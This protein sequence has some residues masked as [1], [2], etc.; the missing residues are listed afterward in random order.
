MPASSRKMTASTRDRVDGKNSNRNDANMITRDHDED[1][2]K[3]DGTGLSKTVASPNTAACSKRNDVNSSS[4]FPRF[5]DNATKV[6]NEER[7]E[8]PSGARRDADREEEHKL[9]ISSSTRGSSKMAHLCS[10]PSRATESS[11]TH[12]FSP[13]PPFVKVS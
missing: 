4:S 5:A 3:N 6:N 10:S 12:L 1:T 11:R 2:G 13:H 9:S 7:T 8:S